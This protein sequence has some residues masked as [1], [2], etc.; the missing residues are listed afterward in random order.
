MAATFNCTLI[1]PQRQVLNEEVIYASIP[2]WDGL[3]GLMTQRAPLVVKLGDGPLRL[4]YPTGASCWFF[5]GGG[6]AQMKD[7][8][9]SLI[10]DEAVAV[11]DIVP[12]DAQASLKEAQA[13]I[14]HSDE[15][16]ARNQRDLHRARTMIELT[17]RST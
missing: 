17:Q 13:F 7:N 1:T 2:G 14:P 4:D 8:R 11:E 12:E 15:E 6:F 10:A 9:L 5:V 16:F 3:L